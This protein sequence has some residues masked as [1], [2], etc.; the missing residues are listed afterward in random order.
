M[1]LN[2]FRPTRV[3]GG[4]IVVGLTQELHK[5]GLVIRNLTIVGLAIGFLSV[6]AE[7]QAKYASIIINAD[8]GEVVEEVNADASSYPA[9]LTKMMTLY[10][11]FEALNKGQL[12]L[13]QFL[14]VS[15]H[16][17]NRAP[18]KLNLVAGESVA[19]QDLILAKVSPETR[20]PSPSG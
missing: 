11:T 9:S 12:K 8:T 14:P 17:A 6:T 1:K 13:D 10:L 4:F 2:H 15:A 16:A 18:S 7:A 20:T 3:L 19:V 5:V